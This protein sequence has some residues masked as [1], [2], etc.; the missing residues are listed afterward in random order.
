MAASK[1]VL[2]CKDKVATKLARQRIKYNVISEK[3]KQH[4]NV[5]VSLSCMDWTYRLASLSMDN[6]S[7]AGGACQLLLYV[8]QLLGESIPKVNPFKSAKVLLS[9]LLSTAAWS[10]KGKVVDFGRTVNLQLVFEFEQSMPRLPIGE[11]SNSHR[12][13]R[14]V[15]SQGHSSRHW[16]WDRQWHVV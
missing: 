6:V 15:A 7:C 9:S 1:P 16:L 2:I 8:A 14:D 13:A 12:L 4:R 10:N 11:H 3:I 5:N